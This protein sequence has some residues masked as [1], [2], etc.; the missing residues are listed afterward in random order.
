[1][2]TE[3]EKYAIINIL[4]LIMEADVIIHPKEVEFIDVV[5]AKLNI[6]VDKLDLIEH[7]DLNF[8][9]SII[10]SMNT[11]K[12]EYAK[13]LFIKMAS[14]DGYIDPRETDVIN[15]LSL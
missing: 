14:I 15:S 5:M 7:Y 1:M 3:I 12:V 11:P 10:Q 6:T 2:F 8:S 9:K 4:S 13:E